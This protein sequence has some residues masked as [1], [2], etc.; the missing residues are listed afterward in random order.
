MSAK[1]KQAEEIRSVDSP[2]S[3]EDARPQ[4]KPE[5]K[6]FRWRVTDEDSPPEIYNWTLYLSVFVFGILGAA[7][8]LDEGNISG[9]KAQISFQTQ[10]GLIDE[11]KTEDEIAQLKSNITSMVQLG[12]IGGC[13]IAMWTVDRFGRIRALQQVCVI[14]IVGAILQIT[15]SSVGQLYAGRLI[16]G[17]AIGQTTTIGPTYMSEVAPRQIRGLCG[18]IFAGA[19]YLGIMIGYFANYGTAL[20]MS[21]ESRNQW[22]VPT[23][24]KIVMAGSIFILS[25]LLSVESPRWLLKVKQ[26][27]KAVRNLSKLRGL[28][29]DHPYVLGEISDINEGLIVESEAVAG[30]SLLSKI[31]EVCFV[32]SIRYRV[33]MVASMAQLLGQWSGANAITIY[34]PELFALSGI[35]G[36]EKLKMTAVLGVVKFISAY[37]SAFFIIDFL[38]RKRALYIGITVQLFSILFF[39]LF[40]TIVPHAADENPNLSVSENHASKAAMAA[41]YIS[42]MGWTMGFNSIQYLL[43]S[44]IFP[45]NIRSFAQSLVMVLHFANQYGN[46]K[47]MPKMLLALNNYG[48]F[49]FFVGVMLISLFWAY[50]FVP[51]VAG[52]SLESMEDIFNLPWYLIGRKGPELCPDYSQINKIH[53]NKDHEGNAYGG[54]IMVDQ[55]PETEW[56][57]NAS[58]DEK[59]VEDRNSVEARK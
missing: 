8:G 41:L 17:L 31:K 24:L 34:A 21:D 47:A 53:Y 50:F 46:S 56:K 22:V 57:E 28:P 44:E 54:D 33:I 3:L 51:E 20:H 4:E 13:L 49:Y 2:R 25:F 40:L 14:W 1:E 7:R 27:E 12:S 30:S 58:D 55:K 10:F 6:K 36:V 38:G 37:A 16:E 11:N 29:E 35:T 18:C 32:K 23:S 39:A 52:R 9:T 59:K 42:G 5:K 45:L 19:V 15:S 48:A 43:G 26:P